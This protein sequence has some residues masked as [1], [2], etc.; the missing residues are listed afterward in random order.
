[1]GVISI[2]Q[3]GGSR[4]G[5]EQRYYLPVIFLGK[6]MYLLSVMWD[7]AHTPLLTPTTDQSNESAKAQLGEAMSFY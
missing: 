5:Q 7:T 1:M 4:L 2:L 3:R 6:H